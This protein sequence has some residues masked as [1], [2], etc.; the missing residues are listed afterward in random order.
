MSNQSQFMQEISNI[1]NYSLSNGSTRN[2]VVSSLERLSTDSRFSSGA[3]KVIT[4]YLN[5]VAKTKEFSQLAL[6]AVLTLCLA[7]TD[8]V[9][10]CAKDRMGLKA[11]RTRIA[12]NF[13]FS[14]LH[15]LVW[16]YLKIDNCIGYPTY[17]N[18]PL[19]MRQR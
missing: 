3:A 17:K 15:H 4:E 12:S 18:A 11:L 9:L 5:S 1:Q 6:W 7:H 14:Q 13:E 10:S 16:E 2:G 19:A 8:F